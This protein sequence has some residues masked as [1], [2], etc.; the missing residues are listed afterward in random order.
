[1]KTSFGR[2]RNARFAQ[3][4]L[5][6]EMKMSVSRRRDANPAFSKS[7]K[8]KENRAR[9]SQKCPSRVGETQIPENRAKKELA[10]FKRS[11]IEKFA[12][13]VD[14][15]L[16]FEGSGDPPKGTCQIDVATKMAIWRRPD[17]SFQENTKNSKNEN[18]R[19]T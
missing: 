6:K 4:N 19:F 5:M 13:R 12:S 8:I 16:T 11:K 18:S 1:M 15:T 17:A 7:P 3:R 14:E 9:E 10:F 2:R